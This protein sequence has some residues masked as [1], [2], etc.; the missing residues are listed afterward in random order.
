[1][2]SWSSTSFAVR[3]SGKPSPL[4]RA[5]SRSACTLFVSIVRALLPADRAGPSGF[6]FGGKT[7]SGPL[8]PKM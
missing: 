8:G 7:L 6:A 1:M 5:G 4:N 2:L 3:T